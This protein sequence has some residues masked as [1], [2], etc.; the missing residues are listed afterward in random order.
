MRTDFAVL[1]L[2]HGR[3]DKVHTIQALKR[4][5]YTGRW[6]LVVD[7]EDRTLPE[8][9][10]RYRERVLVFNKSEIAARFDEA[11][12][13]KEDR[14]S[15]FYARNASFD[16]A[17]SIGARL[18]MQM[19]DDYSH[20]EIRFDGRK[21]FGHWPVA[22]LDRVLDLMLDYFVTIPALSIAMSQGGD[23]L[24]G[25]DSDFSKRKAMNTFLCDVD[26]PFKFVGRINEDVTTYTS[27]GRRGELFLTI[28]AIM[29]MQKP[30][31]SSAGGMTELYFDTGTYVK[32]FY[33]V[34]VT[35]SA[36]SVEEMKTVF[37][38]IHHH[39][40][41]RN[42]AVQIVR[43]KWRKLDDEGGPSPGGIAI[44]LDPD[45]AAG[46]GSS[47]ALGLRSSIFDC[48]GAGDYWRLIE[49]CGFVDRR[50]ELVDA[51]VEHRKAHLKTYDASLVGDLERRWYDTH[52]FAVYADPVYLADLWL[53]WTRYSRK[54]IA[55]LKT[56]RLGD[57]SGSL[58]DAIGLA[59]L[60]VDLG[61]G[62]GYTTAALGEVFGAARVVGTQ[63]V[64]TFQYRAARSIAA[65]RGFELRPDFVGLGR[66]DVVVASEYFE[67]FEEPI[68]HLDDVLAALSPR[69]LVIANGFNGR[70]IGHFESYVVDGGRIPTADMSRLFNAALRAREYNKVKT[71]IWNERP[72]I[73]RRAAA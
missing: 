63:L 66:A 17:R 7:D 24:G 54:G 23:H 50:R 42:C 32:S 37:H 14:R 11:D 12:C 36:V 10:A 9:R 65:E 55:A 64:E 56:A 16:L 38:R 4:Y 26:R 68:A 2:T 29:V 13:G 41:W 1:I 61:C 46:R 67:H 21:R 62:F 58:V 70:S 60:V 20:F 49:R 33:S 3:P 53:C 22:S 34:M 73:W 48:V 47:R 30:T 5:G 43:E 25:G 39:I 44:G 57:G 72:M 19:D 45:P 18:F 15:V 27:G 59:S 52:D 40:R 71:S 51:F 8:Y 69:W 35:P 31:Q 28:P 6:Y